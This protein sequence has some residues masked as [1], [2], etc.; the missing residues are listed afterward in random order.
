MA[1][2]AGTW[3]EYVA[4]ARDGLRAHLPRRDS[5]ARAERDHRLRP[6]LRLMVANPT[7]VNL[8]RANISSKAQGFILVD[9]RAIV[10]YQEV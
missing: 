7:K 6:R 3:G 5:G 2:K 1:L 10:R 9:F 8:I 4:A